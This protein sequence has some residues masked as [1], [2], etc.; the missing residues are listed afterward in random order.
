MRL[1]RAD[2]DNVIVESVEA[3]NCLTP[4][5]NPPRRMA[6]ALRLERYHQRVKRFGLA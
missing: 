1:T 3:V 4:S 2:L 6:R 5:G